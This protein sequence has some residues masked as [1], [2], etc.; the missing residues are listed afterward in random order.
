MRLLLDTLGIEKAD[1][2]GASYGGAVA[3]YAALNYPERVRSLGLIATS[4]QGSIPLLDQ[5]AETAEQ[6]GMEAQI[7]VSLR[8]WFLPETIAENGWAVRYARENVRRARVEDWAAAW[9]AMARLDVLDRVGQLQQ[10]T[11]V[12]AGKQDLSATPDIMLLTSQAIPNATYELLD[13]GTH[14]MVLEQP[15]T[16]AEKLVSFRKRVETE[17][18]GS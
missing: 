11:L 2:Y 18:A 4:S 6:H 8:R 15:D 17:V 13:P 14:M 5:R 12:I 3:Q 1:L 16:L 7:G 9:R 10:P